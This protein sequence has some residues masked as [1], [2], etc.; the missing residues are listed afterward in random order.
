[1]ALNIDRLIKHNIPYE[2]PLGIQRR[3][4]EILPGKVY[5]LPGKGRISKECI[6]KEVS[7][8]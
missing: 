3:Q 5:R 2:F 4:A 7:H 1:M 6:I 8:E